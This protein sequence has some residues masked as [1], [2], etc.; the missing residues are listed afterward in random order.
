MAA[1]ADLKGRFIKSHLSDILDKARTLWQKELACPSVDD[2]H[3]QGL[4]GH[5]QKLHSDFRT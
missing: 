1:K 2:N 5:R 3:K 4:R